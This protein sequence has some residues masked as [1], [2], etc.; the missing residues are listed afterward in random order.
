MPGT[1][2]LT[3]DLD[4]VALWIDTFRS[5]SPS[6]ISRGEYGPEVGLPRI[7]DLLARQS[8]TATFF[9][10]GSVAEL[11]PDSIRLIRDQGHELA[12]HG[13]THK[14]LPGMVHEDERRTL[15]RGIDRLVK[16]S[17]EQPVGF[18]APAWELSF[19]TVEILETFGIRYDSS[20][21]AS[22][23]RPYRARSGDRIEEGAWIRGRASSIWEFPIAWELDDVPYFLVHPPAF[24][25]GTDPRTVGRIW[26]DELDYMVANEPAGLFTLTMHPQVIGRGPRV[27][28][29]ERFIEHARG[30]GCDFSSL[31]HALHRLE[32][33]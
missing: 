28:M 5:S 24:S 2:C 4:A 14:L 6:A 12:S 11:Y 16:A 9:I 29:L 21:F 18:R 31:N 25:G 23:F 20:Q 17:G 8:V 7:L 13:D 30:L 33:S 26:Q 19:Q 32:Q 3:F 15:E 1:V 22:D 27:L 10:P